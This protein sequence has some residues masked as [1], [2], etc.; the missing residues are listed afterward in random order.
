ML[1]TIT[2]INEN[3]MEVFWNTILSTYGDKVVNDIGEML[4][5]DY[6]PS[7]RYGS[8]YRVADVSAIIDVNVGVQKTGWTYGFDTF[9]IGSDPIV[10][11]DP[12]K[13]P[14]LSPYGKTSEVAIERTEIGT[15]K[16]SCCGH[17]SEDKRYA[18]WRSNNAYVFEAVT[19][20]A[21][22][23]IGEQR[24]TFDG[25]NSELTFLHDIIRPENHCNCPDYYDS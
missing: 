11:G 24:Y 13:A 23:Y 2:Y 21:F 4:F 12:D 5:E 15:K 18:I 6:D 17:E 22:V 10:S 16:C 20:L 9:N 7:E 3:E 14:T 8:G 1:I 25:L 19:Q